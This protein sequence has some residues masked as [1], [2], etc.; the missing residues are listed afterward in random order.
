MADIIDFIHGKLTSKE[1]K[2]LEKFMQKE[3]AEI[4]DTSCKSPVQI[5][6]ELIVLVDYFRKFMDVISDPNT[7]INPDYDVNLALL[8]GRIKKIRGC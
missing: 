1:R 7:K 6:T 5:E 3:Q 8:D 4:E 2:Q